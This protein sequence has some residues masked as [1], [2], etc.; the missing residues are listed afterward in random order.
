MTTARMLDS[1]PITAGRPQPP[2][3]AALQGLL[4]DLY[5][6]QRALDPEDGYLLEHGSPRVIANQIRTFHWYRPYL[7]AGGAILD[8]GCNHAPD[9]CLLR[10]WFGDRLSLHSCDFV[11][12]SRFQAF[13]DFAQTDHRRLEEEVQLPFASNCF[14]VVIGSGVLEHTAMDY[15]SLKELHRVIKPEGL[16]VISY[17]P[18][19]LSYGEW[20]RRHVRKREFHRRLYGMSEAKQLLKRSGFYPI[21]SG[22]HTFF[23]ER[24]ASNLGLRSWQRG[25]AKAMSRILPVEVFSSTLYFIAQKVRVM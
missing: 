12:S 16:V 2:D 23:W 11:D 13:H 9:S 10:A 8:W 20:A 22:Y 17:L 1:Q 5:R 14:D 19:W 3:D 21:V 25:L 6:E 18:N 7:P 24:L 15:E 4:E